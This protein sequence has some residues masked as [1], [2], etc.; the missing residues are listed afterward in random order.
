MVK[1]KV[2][3]SCNAEKPAQ[4]FHLN[5]STKDGLQK[6]CK[7]CRKSRYDKDSVV[8]RG[9]KLKRYYKDHKGTLSSIKEYRHKKPE[10]IMLANAKARAKRLNLPL[11]ITVD[12]VVIPD[13]CP[14]LG[15]PLVV[16]DG[17]P[18]ENSPSLDRFIPEKGYV[19]GNISVISYKANRLKSNGSVEDLRKIANWMEAHCA[20]PEDSV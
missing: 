18:T 9:K 8:V 1:T 11:E 16:A 10:L 5:A 6:H 7:E 3:L 14:I 12:D 17:I 2:C 4:D 19:R 13:F 20:H 15:I